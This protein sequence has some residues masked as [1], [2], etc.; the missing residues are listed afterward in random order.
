MFWLILICPGIR[1]F[2]G[3]FFFARIEL[4]Q[5][6]IKWIQKR[7]KWRQEFTPAY[8]LTALDVKNDLLHCFE[9][10]CDSN[11]IFQAKWSIDAMNADKDRRETYKKKVY[12]ELQRWFHT[13]SPECPLQCDLGQI[14]EL[15]AW[16]QIKDM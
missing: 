13:L 11:K 8:T 12:Y 3:Q 16:S 7:E 5:K 9:V 14:D 15:I 10:E 2:G 6:R 4:Y 1:L